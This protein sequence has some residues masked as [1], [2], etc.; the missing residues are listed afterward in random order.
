MR[1]KTCPKCNAPNALRVRV[2][3][4]GHEFY[5]SKKNIKPPK[6]PKRQKKW[7]RLDHDKWQELQRGNVIKIIKGSGP[8]RIK[9]I[10]GKKYKKYTGYR[11]LFRVWSHDKTGLHVYGIGK[12]GG[13][14]YLQMRQKKYNETTGEYSRPYK[15]YLK[16]DL[17]AAR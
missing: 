8:F 15:L 5:I 10:D 4:C 2:C 12:N 16:N 3:K 6:R 9:K 13:H 17:Y 7:I 1:H 11:G 14:S